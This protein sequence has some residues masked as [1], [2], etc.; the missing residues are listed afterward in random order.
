MISVRSRSAEVSIRLLM[1]CI[2]FVPFLVIALE[3]CPRF[4]SVAARVETEH[5]I[6][7]TNAGKVRGYVDN[8]ISVFKGIPYGDDTTK[9]RFMPPVAPPAWEK[10]RDAVD[11]GPIAPQP[12][13]KK[14]DFYPAPREGTQ[15]SEDCLH[16]NVWTPALR[17]AHKR[18]VIV[19]FHG[20][21]YNG[22]SSNVDLY[23]GVR[24]CRRGDVVVV[25]VNHRLNA[26]GFL[27]LAEFGG[28]NFADSGNVGMLDL[29]LALRWVRDNIVEFGGDPG[30]VTI[31]GQSGGGAKC[32]T[33]MAMPD[34]RGLFHRVMTMS[35]QQLTGR[36]REH[37]TDT[38]RSILNKLHIAPD[39]IDEIKTVPMD[40]LLEAMRG[41]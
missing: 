19:W 37:A 34:A 22:W 24:L 41:V 10:I 16:L 33:L 17:D 6:A 40:R 15:V 14:K 21:G 23:D 31:F 7:S 29:V 20:G 1:R 25:T 27:Y 39:H 3:L 4:E 28:A 38:A 13:A 8:G 32:A 5:P 18:P 35:G 30:N 26:F 12:V 2:V 36:T 9:R 11:F